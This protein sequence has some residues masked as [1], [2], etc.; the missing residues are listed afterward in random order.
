MPEGACAVGGGTGQRRLIVAIGTALAIDPEDEGRRGGGR[1]VMHIEA[2]GAAGVDE[3]CVAIECGRLRAP[4][5]LDDRARGGH[6]AAVDQ[7]AELVGLEL[8]L[9]RCGWRVEA[10]HHLRRGMGRGRDE[11]LNFHVARAAVHRAELHEVGPLAAVMSVVQVA[12]SVS[13]PLSSSLA[14]GRWRAAQ[15]TG[16]GANGLESSRSSSEVGA[17]ACAEL[18][19]SRA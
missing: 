5:R 12:G 18:V 7:D 16:P 15:Q 14:G 11:V 17:Y 19:E 10:E 4:F 6:A 8:G 2:D 13:G 9:G 3:R 1:P